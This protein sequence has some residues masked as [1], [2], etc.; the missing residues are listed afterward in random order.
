MKKLTTRIIGGKYKG[1]ALN[2][3]SLDT[4]RSTKSILKE[5]F[6]NVLQ[7]D[8]IDTFFIEAFGGS[9]SIG[10][11]AI[12]RG[13]SRAFFCEIDKRSYKVLQKNCEIIDKK[14]CTTILGDSFET[15]PTLINNTLKN[16]QEQIIVYIDPPFDYRDG[17]DEI[18]NKS[19][20]M[21]EKFDNNQVFLVAFEHKSGLYMPEKIGNYQKFKTKKFGNSSLTYYN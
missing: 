15:I 19:F 21:V 6:F 7:Y 14:S 20:E 10:L 4:T 5:S 11:E 3:P 18:Y 9:G 17:M 8:I 2:L 16:I 13:A 12:S 1:K